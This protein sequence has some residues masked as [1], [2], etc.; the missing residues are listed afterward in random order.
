M[1]DRA[2]CGGASARQRNGEVDSNHHW[3]RQ[4]IG[5]AMFLVDPGHEGEGHPFRDFAHC[6]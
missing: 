4:R 3:E 2:G 5:T 6:E 1:N